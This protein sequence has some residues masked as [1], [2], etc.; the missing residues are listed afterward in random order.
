[1]IS[2][3]IDLAQEMLQKVKLKAGGVG[4]MANAKKTKVMAFNQSVPPQIKTCD[5]S[6]LEVVTEFTYLGSLVSSS[7]EDIKRRIALAWAAVNKLSTIWKST[8]SRQFKVKLFSST[9]ESILLYGCE[10]WTITKKIEKRIDG[11][12]TR[13]LRTALGIPGEIMFATKINMEIS[14]KLQKKSEVG[15][16]SS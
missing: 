10:T 8:L 1:M 13:L 3:Q 16:S 14:R 4:L 11:C 6:T 2:E 5:G 12:Y 7:F 15:D 9:V